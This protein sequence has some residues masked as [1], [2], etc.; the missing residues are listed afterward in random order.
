VTNP[1]EVKI[2]WTGDNEDEELNI[3]ERIKDIESRT[4]SN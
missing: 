2:R 1:T 3:Y 4:H